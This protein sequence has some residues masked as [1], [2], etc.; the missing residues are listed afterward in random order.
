[1]HTGYIKLW[2]RFGETSFFRNSHC[3]HLAIYLL[4]QCNHEPNKFIFD[5]KEETIDR[6]QL[7]TGLI[8]LKESTGISIQ[9]LRT[10]LRTLE[11]VGFLTSKVTN[12]FRVISI[13]KYGEYQDKPTSKLTIHQQST[14]NP[15][16]TNNND[17]NVKNEKNT[18]ISAPDK[19]GA[20]AGNTLVNWDN[21][22]T[23]H[24]RFMAY[25]IKC[26]YPE[27]YMSATQEQ[28]NDKFA[29]YGKAAKEILTAAGNLES[30][31]EILNR[32][33]TYFCK[34]GLSWNLSTI[35]KNCDEFAN[36][37]LREKTK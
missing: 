11:I 36:E 34:Q 21:C 29:R 3:V 23:D 14:N 35:A 16:T 27:L 31:I 2:R 30:A 4:L 28:A 32:A 8:K 24:Q 1:M 25:Y 7:L 22:K 18:T 17:K 5:G 12:R 37:I 33:K 20:L 19:P 10:A 6:G 9:S 13:C 15:L 26:E